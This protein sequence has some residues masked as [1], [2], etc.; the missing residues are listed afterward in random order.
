MIESRNT[1]RK[2][3][4]LKTCECPLLRSPREECYCMD[5]NSNKVQFALRYCSGAYE[6]CRIYRAI[7]GRQEL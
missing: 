2:A 1:C 4:N 3:D 5:M 7:V 6:E